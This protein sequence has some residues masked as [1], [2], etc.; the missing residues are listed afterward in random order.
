MNS[1][2]QNAS[3][4]TSVDERTDAATDP[5]YLCVSHRYDTAGIWLASGDASVAASTD[6]GT[7]ALLA[8]TF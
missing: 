6:A 7:D 1:N 8:V 5:A 3:I 4:G 2:G